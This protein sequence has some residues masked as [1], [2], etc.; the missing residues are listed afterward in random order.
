MAFSSQFKGWGNGHDGSPAVSGT[1]NSYAACTGTAG[2]ATLTTTLSASEGD[3]VLVHQTQHA[4][5]AGTW[6]IVRVSSDGGAT[7]N[8]YT[9]L[10]NSYSTG[11][12]AVLI[13]QYTGGT[14]SGAVT[15]TAWAGSSGGIIALMS[16]GS[17]TITGSLSINGGGFRYGNGGPA[18]TS[19]PGQQGYVGES[20]T[21]AQ[22]S[23]AQTAAISNGGGGGRRDNGSSNVDRPGG[24]GG[25]NG[26]G[27]AT[28]DWAT[29]GTPGTGGS[30]VGGAEL[31]TACF[32]GGGGGGAG[33]TGANGC[34]GGNGSGFILIIAKT[35]TCDSATGITA[36]GNNGAARSLTIEGG[37]GGGAGGS[38][39]V[40]CQ[41][42][43]FGTNKITALA[44][45]GTVGLGDSKAGGAGG[46]GRIR[47]DYLTAISGTT[48]P[49]LSSAQDTSLVV[50]QGEFLP[51]L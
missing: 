22:N 12:Q 42:A 18:G 1:I 38:V 44:G 29:H 31:T 39:L 19:A 11:A 30:A 48:N 41:S 32:G 15:G 9:A 7:L 20:N 47:C 34:A 21:S 28:G 43:T 24:G 26:A 5:A 46:A 25:A 45:A 14:L 36:N 27:G 6:E 13:P 16:N 17:L 23:S 10:T 40:K 35:L 49:S 4:S 8:L 50:I 3:M 37:G 51:F 33:D 2:Q